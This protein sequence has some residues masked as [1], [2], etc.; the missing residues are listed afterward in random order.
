MNDYCESW[1]S[2]LRKWIDCVPRKVFIW[3]MSSLRLIRVQTKLQLPDS[4]FN[5]HFRPTKSDPQLQSQ[6]WSSTRRKSCSRLSNKFCTIL[7]N[8]TTRRRR[9]SRRNPSESSMLSTRASH[10]SVSEKSPRQKTIHT[11]KKLELSRLATRE[12]RWL[13]VAVNIELRM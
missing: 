4:I 9:S 2:K 10:C 6:R 13:E 12:A 3:N 5:K 11:A 8:P 7:T 1:M